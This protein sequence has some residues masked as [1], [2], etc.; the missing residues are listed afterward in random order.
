MFIESL[1]VVFK[2]DNSA[3]RLLV[4]VYSLETENDTLT[5]KGKKALTK[6]TEMFVTIFPPKDSYPHTSM[7]LM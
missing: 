7:F 4:Y 5:T 2:S 1:V 3:R 6:C